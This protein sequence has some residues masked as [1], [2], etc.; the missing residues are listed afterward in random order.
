MYTV[1]AVYRNQDMIEGKGPM[2]LDRVFSLDF[3]ADDY[4]NKQDGV[5]GRK[6]EEGWQKSPFNDWEVRPLT[7]LEHVDDG[8]DYQRQRLIKSAYAKLSP[9]EKEALENHLRTLI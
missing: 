6:P 2:V 1:Y 4:I 9:A 5:M 8:P 3:D 7:I